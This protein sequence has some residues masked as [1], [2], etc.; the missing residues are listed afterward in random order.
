MRFLVYTKTI[1]ELDYDEETRV[2][3]IIYRDGQLRSVPHVDPKI[4]M[5]MVAQL[6]PERSLYL[7]QAAI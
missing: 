7:M 2:L 1:A 3:T 6:P 4:M 5:R